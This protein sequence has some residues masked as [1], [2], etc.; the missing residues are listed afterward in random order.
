MDDSVYR[1]PEDNQMQYAASQNDGFLTYWKDDANDTAA[2]PKRHYSSWFCKS[3]GQGVRERS[4]ISAGLLPSPNVT[5][6]KPIHAGS[7]GESDAK[8]LE[9]PELKQ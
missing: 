9:L 2:Y 8:S 1:P 7:K 3:V 5:V 6:A 4:D